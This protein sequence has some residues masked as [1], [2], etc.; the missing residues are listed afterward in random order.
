MNHDLAQFT[1]ADDDVKC[2][3]R[4]GKPASPI[5]PAQQKNTA[6]DRDNLSDRDPNPIRRATLTEVNNKSA[7]TYGNIKAG[8][9]DYGD[10]NPLTV[11]SLGDSLCAVLVHRNLKKPCFALPGNS[12]SLKAASHQRLKRV[13][14]GGTRLTRTSRRRIG[15][16]AEDCCLSKTDL[17]SSRQAVPRN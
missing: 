7:D 11:H 17:T 12:A 8:D 2:H 9:K 5:V 16:R 13:D 15:H 14:T 1:E 4:T 6:D 3:P 10:R